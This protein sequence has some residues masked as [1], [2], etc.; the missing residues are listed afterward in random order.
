MGGAFRDMAQAGSGFGW[1]W[2]TLKLVVDGA[3]DGARDGARAKDGVSAY[4][5]S[6]IFDSNHLLVQWILANPNLDSPNPR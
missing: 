1:G 3:Q 2:A 5:R 6:M 4:A